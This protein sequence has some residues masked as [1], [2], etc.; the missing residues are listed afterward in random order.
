MAMGRG[1]WRAKTWAEHDVV[2]AWRYHLC[3]M[4]R[5]SGTI[6]RLARRRERRVARQQLRSDHA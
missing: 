6:K 2:T 1:R 3:Y 5:G 4:K